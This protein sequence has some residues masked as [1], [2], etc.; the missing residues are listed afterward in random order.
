L[1]CEAV[2][3]WASLKVVQATSRDARIFQIVFDSLRARDYTTAGAGAINLFLEHQERN[4]QGWTEIVWTK[5][6][7]RKE[8]CIVMNEREI[9]SHSSFCLLPSAF[10]FIL[11]GFAQKSNNR[12]LKKRSE[13][14]F[15]ASE[16]SAQK[17]R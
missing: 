16:D 3:L 7:R 6:K 11:T 5:K 9:A 4:R 12:Y 8:E 14:N 2:K 10:S 17:L 1:V 15:C 13:W